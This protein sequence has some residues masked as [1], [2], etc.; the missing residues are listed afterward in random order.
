ML[1]IAVTPG[2]PAGIGPELL[3]RLITDYQYDYEIV[4]FADRDWLQNCANHMGVEVRLTPVN[5]QQPVASGKGTVSVYH[6]PL[7]VTC[8]P[9]KLDPQNADYVLNTLRQATTRCLERDCHAL[10]TGPV[11]KGVINEAGIAFSG[12]TEFLA[13]LSKVKQVVMMLACEGLRVALAT[14]HLPL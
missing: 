8:C 4:V 13:E 7:C 3:L 10:V 1:R 2:E 5:W 9:G 6:I 12:H 11:H 14:T